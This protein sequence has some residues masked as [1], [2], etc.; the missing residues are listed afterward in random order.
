MSATN[1][2]SRTSKDADQSPERIDD[3]Q[4]GLARLREV[5]R[6]ILRVDKSDL[7]DRERGAKA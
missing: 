5:M 2:A 6:R 1:E 3:P 4:A 7:I